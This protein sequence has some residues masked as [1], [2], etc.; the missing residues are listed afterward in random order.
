MNAASNG[1]LGVVALLLDR[2]ANVEAAINV[3]GFQ[4]VQNNVVVIVGDVI[5]IVGSCHIYYCS[6]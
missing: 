6:S 3:I 2:G 5:D 4:L 1:H